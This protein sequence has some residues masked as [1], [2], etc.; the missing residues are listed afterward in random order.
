[1]YWLGYGQS[2]IAWRF[3]T[4]HPAVTTESMLEDVL[5]YR[6]RRMWGSKGGKPENG[7][8]EYYE[9]GAGQPKKKP[10][11]LNLI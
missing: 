3:C 8:K 11:A 5:M 2:V 7:C 10:Y 4:Y 9:G 6:L 1:M